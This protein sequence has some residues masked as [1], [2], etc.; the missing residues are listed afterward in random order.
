MDWERHYTSLCLNWSGWSGTHDACGWWMNVSSKLC[1]LCSRSNLRRCGWKALIC[2]CEICGLIVKIPNIFFVNWLWWHLENCF[3]FSNDCRHIAHSIVVLANLQSCGKFVV[4]A[5]LSFL[6]SKTFTFTHRTFCSVFTSSCWLVERDLAFVADLC[7]CN[8]IPHRHEWNLNLSP[9]KILSWYLFRLATATKSYPTMV[10]HVFG[11]YI[12]F[13]RHT[14]NTS[15]FESIFCLFRSALTNV[16]GCAIKITDG[17]F[18]CC[19]GFSL[20]LIAFLLAYESEWTS[21]MMKSFV[22]NSEEVFFSLIK[23]Y[24][25]QRSPDPTTTHLLALPARLEQ[26]SSYGTR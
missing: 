14:Q 15:V 20:N 13:S 6:S 18:T 7:F 22:F 25:H 4:N 8:W 11:F 19:E 24:L 17:W 5:N 1:G 3:L 26:Q 16:R 21:T 2:I 23:F 10:S 12:T 9:H